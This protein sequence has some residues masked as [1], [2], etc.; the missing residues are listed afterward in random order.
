MKSYK[1]IFTVFVSAFLALSCENAEFLNR[2]PYSSTAPENF[3]SNESQMRMALVSC[4]E[5]MNT[6][7]IPGLGY[8]QRGSYAQGLIY[9]MNAPC[10]DVVGTASS[11]G[12]GIEMEMGTFDES[13]RC[14]RD[15]W[16]VYYSGINR[17]NTILAYI[18]GIAGMSEE[19]KTQFKAEARF[20]RAFYYYHLAWNFGGVPIVTN[21]ASDGSESRSSLKD[22]YEQIILP[23]F[24]Y[25]YSN[26]Q[27]G[28]IPNVSVDKYVAAAYIGKMCNYL[29]A[30]KRSGTGSSFVAEQPL[31]DFAWVDEAAMSKRA[32]EV[33]YDVCINSS[34]VLNDDYRVNF[35]EADKED[36]HK[37]ALMISEIPLSGTEGYWPNSYYLPVMVGPDAWPTTYGGRHIPTYRIFYMYSLKDQR[38]DWNLTGRA[39]DGHTEWLYKGYTYAVP[40]FRDSVTVYLKDA[41][42]NNLLD[43]VTGASLKEKILHPLIQTET[44][45]YIPTTNMQI[46]SGKFRFAKT[47]ELQRTYQQSAISYPLMRLADVYLMYAE[48]LYFNGNEG[49]A[50]TWMNKVLRRAA[51]DEENYNELLAEYHRDN[52]VDE[53]IESRSRELFMEFSR[54]WDLIRFNRIDAAITSMNSESF[55]EEYKGTP[56][57]DPKY[58]QLSED[59]TMRLL[60]K[61]VQENWMPYKIWL[62]ISEEQRGVNKNL[63]QNAGW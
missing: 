56:D 15:F 41:E 14:I 48:A 38:R 50:R 33:L 55:A 19:Q 21:Y 44:Q 24:E 7:K 31:N 26:L 58:L 11:A 45:T 49:E 63:E 62:P 51:T 20:M 4:Y 60:I 43:P 32:G 35:L 3:Y 17:C 39:K 1:L 16:K 6:H 47:D 37:E 18:D 61:T 22:V 2:S 8:C 42:G 23:D 59:S 54:K 52:F 46:C 10:D 27:V 40:T 9:L 57:I 29:A 34:Y 12:E 5:T 36:Q 53:L 25:A 30:C 13:S 28:V